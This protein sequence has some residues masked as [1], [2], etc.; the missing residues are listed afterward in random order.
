LGCGG[1]DRLAQGLKAAVPLIARQAG[2]LERRE[3][4]QDL[5]RRLR[6]HRGDLGRDLRLAGDTA[7][8]L[9]RMRQ[10]L[11]LRREI[12]EAE[13]QSVQRDI[14]QRLQL[15]PALEAIRDEGEPQAGRPVDPGWPNGPRLP[16]QSRQG[17]LVVRE[18]RIGQR[19]PRGEAQ[20]VAA[21]APPCVRSRQDQLGNDP[22]PGGERHRRRRAG[23][24]DPQVSSIHPDAAQP[25]QIRARDADDVGAAVA[26]PSPIKGHREHPEQAPGRRVVG[27]GDQRLG[28]VGVEDLPRAGWHRPFRER[29]GGLM[30]EQ[31][32]VIASARQALGQR[33]AVSGAGVAGGLRRNSLGDVHDLG[34]PRDWREFQD[35]HGCS[36][37]E[38]ALQPAVHDGVPAGGL[39]GELRTNDQASRHRWGRRAIAWPAFVPPN[40]EMSRHRAP[41][42]CCRAIRNAGKVLCPGRRLRNLGS[43]AKKGL[44]PPR[45]SRSATPGL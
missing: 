6:H 40:D 30:G 28:V 20:E 37:G 21:L 44:R 19:R 38:I 7:D 26:E 45:E 11:E 32:R 42:L 33:R 10:A 16:A 23:R 18:D 22:G 27:A 35:V 14:L 31:H 5:R 3:P 8:E 34:G 29:E 17:G 12:A 39:V 36:P 13:D 15:E 4:G 41:K 2:R 25:E 43:K 24:R 1:V 9:A